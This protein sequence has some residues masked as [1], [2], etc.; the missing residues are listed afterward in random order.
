M[1]LLGDPMVLGAVG[2]VIGFSYKV[3]NEHFS[4]KA[5]QQ[6]DIRNIKIRRDL[7]KLLKEYGTDITEDEEIIKNML[8]DL[9]VSSLELYNNS[10]YI[11]LN[12]KN[13]DKKM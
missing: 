5:K 4:T 7:I 2:S 11:E 12:G 3:Y 10:S 8:A 1:N 6:K 9:E 13:M